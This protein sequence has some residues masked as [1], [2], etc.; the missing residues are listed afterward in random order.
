MVV[1]PDVFDIAH[2]FE[3][4]SLDFMFTLDPE[5]IE[6]HEYNICA[7]RGRSKEV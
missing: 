5:K 6:K 7:F 2:A 3:V 4:S 1:W